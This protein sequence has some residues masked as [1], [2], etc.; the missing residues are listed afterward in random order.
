V[1]RAGRTGIDWDAKGREAILDLLSEKFVAPWAEIEARISQR[2]WK[3]FPQVQPVQLGGARRKLRDEDELIKEE[4]SKTTPPVTMV[5]IRFPPGQRKRLTRL[6]GHRRRKYRRYLSWAGNHAWCG[7]HA[8]RV[9]LDSALAVMSE[10]GLWVPPQTP[11]RIAEVNGIPVRTGPLDSLAH[12]LEVPDVR[13][14]VAL[15]FEVKNIHGWVYP[16]SL[17]LWEPLV[18][19]A[20]LALKTPVMFVLVCVRSAWQ[21]GQ[22]AKDIGFLSCQLW[23]QFFSP[24]IRETEFE[25][26]VDEFGLVMTQHAGPWPQVTDFLTK[27]LRLSPPKSKPYGEDIPW[28]RR[29]AERLSQI[30]PLVLRYDALAGD[31]PDDQRRKV[32][33]AFKSELRTSAPWPLE[34]GY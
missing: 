1:G 3:D 32:F 17:S 33:G 18:K 29:Q 19:A 27:T 14:D 26:M 30:A 10:A 5:R 2:G 12:I 6:A 21:T 25:E 4:T 24:D 7:K 34:A 11:G 22:L 28:Y 8:E 20:D 9:V 16:W 31:L 15:V 13:S 23:S